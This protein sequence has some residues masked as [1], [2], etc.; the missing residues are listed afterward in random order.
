MMNNYRIIEL[1]GRRHE[2]YIPF[3]FV[4][5]YNKNFQFQILE[6]L[7]VTHKPKKASNQIFITNF[8]KVN[9]FSNTYSL[10]FTQQIIP[11]TLILT[12]LVNFS[13]LMQ[14][15][16]FQQVYQCV[17]FNEIDETF[18]YQSCY[19]Q[20]ENTT[21]IACSC[22]SLN[23]YIAVLM[24]KQ[25]ALQLPTLDDLYMK[26]SFKFDVLQTEKYRIH[27]V[28]NNSQNQVENGLQ[29]QKV[30]IRLKNIFDINNKQAIL[31]ILYIIFSL[32]ISL[33]IFAYLKSCFLDVY[34]NSKIIIN[35]SFLYYFPY[36]ALF[37]GQTNNFITNSSRVSTFI[38]IQITHL[39]LS[40]I[41]C[42]YLNF[43]LS[44]KIYQQII[45]I[46]TITSSIIFVYL[47]L[48]IF[49]LIFLGLNS[50]YQYQD[51]NKQKIIDGFKYNFGIQMIFLTTFLSFIFILIWQLGNLKEEYYEFW[52]N[53]VYMTFYF[54]LGLDFFVMLIVMLIGTDNILSNF[55]QLRGFAALKE[56]RIQLDQSSSLIGQSIIKTKKQRN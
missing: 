30:E 18:N 4:E 36:F 32:L 25:N 55:I 21:H 43:N 23:G 56:G 26:N 40:A 11:A 54:D 14:K 5:K 49:N 37:F 22:Y 10:N 42:N 50:T 52:T 47:T 6:D 44:S 7:A 15:S 2:L 9:F 12:K 41:Y 27:Q 29:N 19:F 51:I 34:I 31:N 17:E 39:S 8:Y 24:N 33:H 38:Y 28:Y 13:K 35:T 45:S 3:D 20:R 48:G 53:I 1:K 16:I 46:I